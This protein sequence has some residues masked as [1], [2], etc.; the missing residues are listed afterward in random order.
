MK[1]HL[2]KVITYFHKQSPSQIF[3][4][5]LNT[6]FTLTKVTISFN[7]NLNHSN[8]KANNDSHKRKSNEGTDIW[9]LRL[10]CLKAR[11]KVMHLSFSKTICTLSESISPKLPDIPAGYKVFHFSREV[12]KQCI[13]PVNYPFLKHCMCVS[14]QCVN[15]IG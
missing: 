10:G 12:L 7:S 13:F 3:D 8:K 14:Q 9:N 15:W 1:N 11:I 4:G 6:P 2:L 5:V